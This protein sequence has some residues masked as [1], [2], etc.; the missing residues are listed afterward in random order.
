M[1]RSTAAPSNSSMSLVIRLV[2]VDDAADFVLSCCTA[3]A[4]ISGLG[5]SRTSIGEGDA[6]DDGRGESDGAGI[7]VTTA[8]GDGRRVLLAEGDGRGLGLGLSPAG[9][10]LGEGSGGMT[11]VGELDGSARRVLLGEGLGL[12][13]GF[14]AAVA[15]GEGEGVG[16][17]DAAEPSRTAGSSAAPARPSS[18]GRRTSG[19]H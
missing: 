18:S 2:P 4:V 8:V 7:T 17:A 3:A 19:T 16:A 1:P 15:F 6:V 10:R 11:P 14:A 5:E 12:A 13:L 9:D